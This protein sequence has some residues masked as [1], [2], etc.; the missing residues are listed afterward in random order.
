MFTTSL[1]K[2]EM[3]T[4]QNSQALYWADVPSCKLHYWFILPYHCKQRIT[5]KG[6]KINNCKTPF[7]GQHKIF[8]YCK[9]ISRGIFKR[10]SKRKI[11]GKFQ[12][13]RNGILSRL[14]SCKLRH[15]GQG[16]CGHPCKR[17]CFSGKYIYLS[18]D[19]SQNNGCFKINECH[20]P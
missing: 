4:C 2:M 19:M 6:L 5:E 7:W 20:P 8:V 10:Q 11:K 1:A 18:N 3:A 13:I 17:H 15:Y 16:C 9:P 12:P 14:D